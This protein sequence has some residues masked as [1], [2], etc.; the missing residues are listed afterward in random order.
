MSDITRQDNYE[1]FTKECFDILGPYIVS[2][3]LKDIQ[4]LAE[5]IYSAKFLT[6]FQSNNLFKYVSCNPTKEINER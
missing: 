5:C 1:E 4:L 6:E 3:H 2:C